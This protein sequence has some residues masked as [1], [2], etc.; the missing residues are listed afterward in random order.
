MSRKMTA[1]RRKLFV[2]LIQVNDNVVLKS[3]GCRIQQR[4]HVILSVAVPVELIDAFA[5]RF[6]SARPL[7]IFF[8]AIA[9]ENELAGKN[10]KCLHG[11]VR[12]DLS[13]IH[14]VHCCHKAIQNGRMIDRHELDDR[15]F[16]V[17]CGANQ[18]RTHVSRPHDRKHGSPSRRFSDAMALPNRLYRCRRLPV[19]HDKGSD[20]RGD[21]ANRLKPRC[22]SGAITGEMRCEG[23]TKESCSQT[24]GEHE[25]QLDHLALY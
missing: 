19:S 20:D 1:Q 3:A 5:R 18:P 22:P 17:H 16:S 7:E 15:H 8:Q 14:A 9:Q 2:N 4:L 24:R 25:N 23:P 21:R 13:S 6:I 10:E 12:A 11:L